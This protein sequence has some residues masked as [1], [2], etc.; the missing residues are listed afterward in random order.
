MSDLKK[1]GFAI[2]PYYPFVTN[3]ML[4]RKYMTV[5][6]HV[7]GLNISHVKINKVT[8]MIE[9]IEYQYSKMR[10]YIGKLH[11]YLGMDLD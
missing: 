4:N 5:K 8:R 7:N 3:K 9:W 1:K 2:N 6:W 11:D 10:I